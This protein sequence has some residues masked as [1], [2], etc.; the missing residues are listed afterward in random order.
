MIPE[1]T[2]FNFLSYTGGFEVIAYINN[3]FLILIVSIIIILF[4]V[5]L[6]N[7]IFSKLSI[8]ATIFVASAITTGLFFILQG[9]DDSFSIAMAMIFIFTYTLYFYMFYLIGRAEAINSK[10]NI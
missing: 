1:T 6:T 9:M 2:P 3:G 7:S 5:R 8:I 10:K 4:S